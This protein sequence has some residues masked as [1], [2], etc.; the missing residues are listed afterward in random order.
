MLAIGHKSTKPA[1]ALACRNL[2]WPQS[3]R[4]RA[5]ETKFLPQVTNPQWFVNASYQQESYGPSND[6]CSVTSA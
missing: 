6:A 1:S 3:V 4:A 2:T 5:R